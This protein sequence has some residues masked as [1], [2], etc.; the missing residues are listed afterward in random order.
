VAVDPTQLVGPLVLFGL[1]AV[2]GLELT[3]DDFRRVLR[4]PRAVLGATFAQILLLP[5]WTWCV[6]RGLEVSPVF[7][8]GAVLIALSPGAGI[9]NIL[10]ALAGANTALSVTL[11]ALA[12]LLAVV[13][14]PTIAAL[15]MGFFLGEAT[16][17]EVPVLLLFGQLFFALLLP[18]ALGM[19]LR[20][21]RPGWAARWKRRL[22]HFA[23]AGIALLTTAG[24]ASGGGSGA[25]LGLASLREG[26]VAAAVWTL[27]AMAL[28]WA[29]A[30]AL[31]L[32]DADRF[33]CLIEFSTRNVAVAAIVA[34]SGLQ[35]VDLVLFSAGYLLIGYPLAFAAVV[36]RRRRSSA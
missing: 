31:G 25:E 21:R 11:T 27:G 32:P 30:F 23:M 16:A 5:L 34:L 4:A 15:G 29:V 2:V 13:T 26:V 18:I 10:T 19:W 22:Q 24:F 9:S 6:V 12:S 20:A 33:T 3:R 17:V 35:R 36:W 7:G 14:L 1:M 28:G 8:A